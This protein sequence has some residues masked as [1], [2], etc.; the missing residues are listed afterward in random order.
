MAACPQCSKPLRELARRCPSCQ[1][2]LDLL[3]D[4]VSHLQGGI[5]RA[6]NLTRAG[7]LGDAVW[8]YLEVLETE[9][10]NAPARRQVAR[11]VTAVRQFDMSTP[12]R[13]IASGIPLPDDRPWYMRLP[14]GPISLT[15]AGL[16]VGMMLGVGMTRPPAPPRPLGEEPP[17]LKNNDAAMGPA[18]ERLPPPKPA[19]MPDWFVGPP[20]P[21]APPVPPGP[22]APPRHGG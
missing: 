3:V 5:Q 16:F 9:P 7:E 17:V 14:L 13:R 10:D 20:P 6:E 12:A 15:L 19:K 8:A 4:F 21:P 2:D 11:V 22:P 18:P 1:A